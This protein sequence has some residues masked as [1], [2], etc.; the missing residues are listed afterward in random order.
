MDRKV[1]STFQAAKICR[2]APVT[3]IRWIEAGKLTSYKTPGGH[4]RIREQDLLAFMENHGLP[5][6]LAE[7]VSR[8]KILIID[9]EMVVRKFIQKSLESSDLECEC[10][11]SG[12]GIDALLKIGLFQP[13]VLILD[14]NIPWVDGL[15]ICRRIRNNE[16]TQQ[17]KVITITGFLSDE[18]K[19]EIINSGANYL[20]FK[21]FDVDQLLALT[22]KALGQG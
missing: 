8:P 6:Y 11:T 12:D 21:P 17:I 5:R 1:F 19:G 22:A 9:D 7:E 20:L 13:D 14:I 15:E 2:V 16:A 3:I 4:R 10:E 18:D